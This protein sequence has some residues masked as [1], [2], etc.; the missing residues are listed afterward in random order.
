MIYSS[1]GFEDLSKFYAGAPSEV[2]RDLDRAVADIGRDVAAGTRA[3]ASRRTVRRTGDLVAGI[4]AFPVTRGQLR[5]FGVRSA[6][7]HRGYPYPRR[8]EFEGRLGTYGPRASLLPTIENNRQKIEQR[9]DAV[10]NDLAND[11]GGTR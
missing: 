5:G 1:K 2:R 11:F 9:L 3:L 7:V 4:D 6:A 10:L 8:L